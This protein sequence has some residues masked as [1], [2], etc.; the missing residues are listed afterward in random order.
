MSSGIYSALSGAIAQ[1]RNLSV[2]ANNVAN[3]STHGYKADRVAFNEALAQ[4]AQAQ[5]ERSVSMRYAALNRVQVDTSAGGLEVTGRP[6][7][8]ALL[9]DAY[10]TVRSGGGDQFTRA[11]GFLTDASGVVRNHRGDALLVEGGPQR[12]EGVELTIPQGTRTITV[13]EDGTIN[14]DG[15]SLGK[16]RLRTFAR[17]EDM[18]KVG[19]THFIPQAGITPLNA[20]DVQLVQGSLETANLN[21]VQGLNEMITLSR[22]FDALQRVIQ[23]FRSV[24]DR[25]VRDLAG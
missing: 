1:E 8:F 4:Q 20:G 12:P 13:G 23:T 2:V 22:S 9:G 15:Q 16:L 11:G 3:V 19:S 18:Q 17:P 14:A 10:F 5:P 24:D 25:T 21:A 6:L 7:D